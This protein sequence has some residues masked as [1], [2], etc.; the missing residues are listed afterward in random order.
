MWNLII[1]RHCT[2]AE[3]MC[4]WP[5]EYI[6]AAPA[7]HDICGEKTC[8][9]Y[10]TNE[11]FETC[12][13]P[14]GTVPPDCRVLECSCKY[15]RS[16][17]LLLM[18]VIFCRN[19][20]WYDMTKW[21]WRHKLVFSQRLPQLRRVQLQVTQQAQPPPQQQ[22][23]QRRLRRLRLQGSLLHRLRSHQVCWIM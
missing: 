22:P 15:F 3:V 10:T 17:F 23:Q 18:T 14:P 6:P 2:I 13:C 5:K 12:E 8:K 20:I 11:A 21:F 9:N 4:E 1:T 19:I 7:C 16:V